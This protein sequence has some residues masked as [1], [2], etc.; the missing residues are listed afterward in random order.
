MKPR[1]PRTKSPV[2]AALCILEERFAV[3]LIGKDGGEKYRSCT[4]ISSRNIFD[5]IDAMPMRRSEIRWSEMR[6][7]D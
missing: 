4:P 5:R 7:N 2:C 1:F 6:R 3:V